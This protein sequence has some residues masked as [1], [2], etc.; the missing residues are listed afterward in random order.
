[1]TRD[2]Q[3][4]ANLGEYYQMIAREFEARKDL[5]S[6][7]INHRYAIGDYRETILRQLLTE[8]FGGACAVVSGFFLS[9]DRK[10]HQHD[11][12]MVDTRSRV[13][14]RQHRMGCMAAG[15]GGRYHQTR[16]GKPFAM[17]THLIMFDDLMLGALVTK[18]RRFTFPVAFGAEIRNVADKNL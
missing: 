13:F 8:H 5:L 17:N 16:F 14:R 15:T 2:D 6:T 18:R 9:P 1:M 11:I 12:L 10:S 4:S 7:L 3:D